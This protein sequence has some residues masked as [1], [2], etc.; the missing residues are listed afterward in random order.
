MT[1]KPKVLPHHI[2]KGGSRGVE[3]FSKEML[4]L[5]KEERELR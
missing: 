2:S 5:K 4:V 3:G 1:T